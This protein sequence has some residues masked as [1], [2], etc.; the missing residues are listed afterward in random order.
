MITVT[1]EEFQT[2]AIQS[3]RYCLG[4]MTYAVDDNC[5]FNQ[6]YWHL[7]TNNTRELITRELSDGVRRHED[8]VESGR[9][10]KY[11]RGE[12]GSNFD[13]RTWK[14]LLEWINKQA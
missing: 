1:N 5:E 3:F 12:L 11:Q 9:Y 2:L 13:Y 4:R 14:N 10:D 6:K 8:D 7:F